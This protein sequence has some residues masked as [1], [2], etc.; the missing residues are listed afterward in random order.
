MEEGEEL[1][2]MR[3]GDMCLKILEGGKFKDVV[4]KKGEVSFIHDGQL[5]LFLVITE[6][7]ADSNNLHEGRI[8]CAG[9]FKHIGK[10]FFDMHANIV[11][12]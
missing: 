10:I 1:F 3:E 2:Y 5:I 7:H 6:T 8:G 12:C 11:R 9:P 4:I